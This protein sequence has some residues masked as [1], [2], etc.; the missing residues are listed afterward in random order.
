LRLRERH[1]L[2]AHQFIAALGDL[3]LIVRKD[4]AV[5]VAATM[6]PGWRFIATPVDPAIMC[7][8]WRGEE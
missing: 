3:N 4:V 8:R 6:L 2:A 5:V 7:N 1:D